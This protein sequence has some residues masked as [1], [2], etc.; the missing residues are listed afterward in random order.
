MR[1]LTDDYAALPHHGTMRLLEQVSAWDQAQIHCLTTSHHAPDNP[2]RGAAHLS[3]VQSVEYAAQAAALHGVLLGQLAGDSPVL[4]LGAVQNLVLHI[5]WLD[6]VAAPL[7]VT[8]QRDAAVGVNV[9]YHFAV[10]TADQPV[11]SGQLTL[12]RSALVRP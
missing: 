12:L 6:Q 1:D 10:F 2:L 3:A 9:R 5:N 11:A 8:A 4:F 7:H